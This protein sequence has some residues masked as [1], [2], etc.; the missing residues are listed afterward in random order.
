MSVMNKAYIFAAD[1]NG[2]DVLAGSLESDG[3]TGR[4]TYADSWLAEPWT[5][6]LDPV[7]LPLS[8]K[9]YLITNK[10][11]VHAVFS[12]AGPDDWG[13]RIM[14]FHNTS[15][16][17][18]ELERLLR[19]SGGGV[20]CL[21]FSGSRSRPKTPKPLPLLARIQELVQVVDRA[22][23][24]DSL[25]DEE[26][27]L[28]DGGSSLGGARPK[29]S[30]IDEN[31][32]KWLVKFSRKSEVVSIPRLEYASMTFCSKYLG[33]NTPECRLLDL[34]NDKQAFMIRRFD[35]NAHFISAY[36]LINEDR[37]RRIQDSKSNPYSY[38]NIATILRKHAENFEVDCNQLFKRMVANVL[39]GNTDDHSRNHAM[40]FDIPKGTWGLSP[41][42]DMLPSIG[43]TKGDQAIGVGKNGS[44][45]TREN[46][47]SYCTLFLVKPQDAE[48]IYDSFLEGFAT[49]WNQ[50]ALDMGV[51]E[52]E[53]K[54]INKCLNL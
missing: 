33:I 4:F 2:N 28:I 11:G 40:L 51:W 24:Q 10:K 23:G 13:T 7:N 32:D 47:L 8:P 1:A 9:P 17:A 26:L 34:G 29:V 19:T 6:P 49:H 46:V 20:G 12:D 44:A 48:I 15:A 37:V 22:Q 25:T 30:C 18:N 39:L 27:A 16:P 36:G 52:S 54:I 35:D 14:L 41:A 5:Y 31:G 38:V 45:S 42:Y 53:L 43:G 21:R 3:F 50:H